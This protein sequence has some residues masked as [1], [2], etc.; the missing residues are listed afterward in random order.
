MSK[1]TS[2]ALL[3]VL[4]GL[5]AV[6][7][8]WSEGGTETAAPA[9]RPK[10]T[11][12]MCNS[13]LAHPAGIDPSNNWAIKVIEDYANVDLELEVPTY[14]DFPVKLNLL[15]ASGNLPDI[16]HT[17][18]KAD[19]V[20]AADA[21][22]FIDLK[23]YWDKSPQMQKVT[24]LLNMDLVKAESTKGIY[25]AIPMNA[26]GMEPGW[27]I[28]VRQDLIEKYNGGKYP[29]DLQGYLN[30]FKAIKTAIPDSIPVA[31]RVSPPT[32]FRNSAVIL[33]I[34]GL[35]DGWGSL[36]WRDGKYVPLH[37]R[38]RVRRG[39]QGLPAALRRRHPGQ[40][41]RHRHRR[42]LLAEGHEQVRR[43]PDQHPRPARAGHRQHHRGQRHQQDPRGVVD[44]RPAA[45]DLPRRREA[46][47]HPVAE[48]RRVPHPGG[49]PRGHQREVEVPRRWRGR[50]SKAS[51]PTSSAT[52]RPGAARA[53]EY[54]DDQR[55]ARAH[56]PSST[57]S[58][59]TLDINSH[60]WTLSP[61]HHL[62]LL[63]HRG[64]VRGPAH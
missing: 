62:G 54:N 6:T 45:Q 12:F 7:V 31:S 24:P 15:L 2:R 44:L 10:V 36:Y 43:H 58:D 51:P 64:E 39:P 29:E 37:R 52:C 41:V 19:M 4:I 53:R 13:G 63:A 9:A 18:T 57:P 42:Q 26:I 28:I 17:N 48:R 22:A 5:L 59:G 1:R 60:G 27:G 20:K 40:G 47:V 35:R 3:L 33:A 16:V 14:N 32:F 25:Y 61:R 21:G 50:S 55:Q 49:S 8:A 46:R 56:H 23:A 34:F 11:M 30:W 38:A